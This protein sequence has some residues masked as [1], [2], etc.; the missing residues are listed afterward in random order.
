MAAIDQSVDNSIF[1][2]QLNKSY[3]EEDSYVNPS[4]VSK[5]NQ[6][7]LQYDQNAS[8]VQVNTSI[9]ENS[10]ATDNQNPKA[11]KIAKKSK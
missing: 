10:M 2:S 6:S 7:Y 4:N 3:E 5:I 1:D 9:L 11:L 8:L